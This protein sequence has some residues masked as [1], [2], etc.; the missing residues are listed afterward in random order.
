MGTKQNKVVV[1][2]SVAGLLL[3][4]FQ[5]CAPQE[6]EAADFS[7]EAP[8]S[9]SVVDDLEDSGQGR[10]E[11]V[12]DLAVADEE[13]EEVESN[14]KFALKAA[15]TTVGV[16]SC[17]AQKLAE[18][19]EPATATKSTVSVNCNLTLKSNQRISKRL[20][21]QGAQASNIVINCNGAMIDEAGVNQGRDM[22]YVVSQ[23]KLV[24]G[25][26]TWNR[27]EN[28][29][30]EKCQV[31]GSVRI[32]GMANNGE[33]VD[34]KNSSYS[35]DHTQRARANAPTKIT[36]NKMTITG[37]GRIPL[38]I[39]PG[40]TYVTLQNSSIK[41]R[42]TSTS[43]YL[44]TESAYNVIRNNTIAAA[45]EKREVMA[46]DGSAYNKIYGNYFSGLNN[47]GIFLYRN[48]G[49]GGTIRHQSPYN[50]EIINNVFYYN[51]FNG[52]VPAVWVAS[53]NGNRNYCSHDNGYFFGSSVNN[54]D[55]VKN[56]VI[57]QNRFYKLAPEKMI[58]LNDSPNYIAANAEVTS[59]AARA[60]GCFV[61]G[62]YPSPYI[63]SGKTL[64]Y[65]TKNNGPHCNG[66]KYSC[67][68]GVVTQ[69][70]WACPA[71]IP[72][73]EVAFSCQV[74]GNSNGCSKTVSCPAGMRIRAAK[75]ACN[76]ESGTV[77]DSI[78]KQI[79]ANSLQVVRA[80]D[81]AYESSC[82]IDSL[83]LQSGGGSL[84]FLNGAQSI[85]V[86]CREHDK[87]GG[88]CHIR[89][90]LTCQ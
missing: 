4:A 66:F 58:R 31:R 27:P 30:I 14:L 69:T 68:D 51:K 82:R 1:V 87:N 13:E 86:H 26:A 6:F 62:G 40:A 29:T 16:K 65:L 37:S 15:A 81:V 10:E 57:F 11:E 24:N 71:T 56:T 43:V 42:T 80:S 34:L 77:T 61:A 21:I 79:G 74:S 55:L 67:Q 8:Y 39:A 9:F 49:E 53:R 3:V 33:G 60:S 47:G 17:S 90:T 83:D 22:I 45:T 76:L 18:V 54:N 41:G 89:G 2:G 7:S 52:S 48:C 59:H 44:D 38:Y 75:A 5:N 12:E 73:Q 19:L 25:V 64:S 50:N 72:S 35:A 28:V 23:K 46:I 36:L 70:K 63:E 85:N 84:A 88:D 78:L 32:A 20:A